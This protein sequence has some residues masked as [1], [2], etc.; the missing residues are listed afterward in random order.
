MVERISTA[1]RYAQLIAD[2]KINQFNFNR[3]TAQLSSGKKLTSITDD[4]IASVNYVNTARQLG[5]IETFEQNVN[6]ATSELSALDDFM[7]LARGYLQSAWDKAVQANN[8]TYGESSLRALK[9]EIDEITKTMVDLANSEYD[10]N[11]VFSGANTK[12]IPYEIDEE[13]YINYLGTPHDNPDYIRMTEVADGVFE[14]INTTGDKVFG[15][16][17]KADVIRDAQGNEVTLVPAH[18]EYQ[19]S[20][21][22]RYTGPV[23]KLTDAFEDT[24]G[25]IV[26]YNAEEDK[27]YYTNGSEYTGDTDD[28]TSIKINNHDEKI[29]QVSVPDKYYNA[30]GTEYTGNVNDLTTTSE[31]RA[32][33]VM[34]ALKL[35]SKSIQ[36]VLDGDTTNGYQLMNETLDRFAKAHE[37]ILR[38]QT[39]FGGVYNRMEM[40]SSTLETTGDN[41]TTYLS[42]L[43]SID[44]ATAITQWMNAQYAYQASMQVAA[45]SMNMSLLNYM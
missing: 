15:Y 37:D 36:M 13:G 39:K 32:E 34:G 4:P 43:N 10:D 33:G 28:L 41:L 40:S 1:T 35:L 17:M 31:D 7:E 42:D 8:Q 25:N 23:S 21:G 19:Y 18:D 27:Y 20:N 22:K 6:M 45:S 12:L 16:Y 38:E 9:T 14:V 44:Y 3:L 11:Y 24:A 26:K 2:M 5:K 29:T 30:D